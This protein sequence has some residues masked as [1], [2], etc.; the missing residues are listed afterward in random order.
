MVPLAEPKVAMNLSP[1]RSVPVMPAL[2][3]VTHRNAS[4]VWP[5]AKTSGARLNWGCT[6]VSSPAADSA[7]ARRRTSPATA[8]VRDRLVMLMR[9]PDPSM[10][11]DFAGTLPAEKIT[12]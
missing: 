9:P 11:P 7:A 12:T 3:L 8:S 4:D 5:T 2:P 10:K 1:G 6:L